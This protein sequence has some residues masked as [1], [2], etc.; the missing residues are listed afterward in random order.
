MGILSDHFRGID[1]CD[2]IK[3][4]DY[5]SPLAIHFSEFEDETIL[6]DTEEDGTKVYVKKIKKG[7]INGD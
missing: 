1:Q 2:K 5:D 7:V 3:I 6:V 4:S